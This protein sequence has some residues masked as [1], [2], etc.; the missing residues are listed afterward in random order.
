MSAA[1]WLDL[2]FVR[3]VMG[4]HVGFDVIDGSVLPNVVLGFVFRQRIG[5]RAVAFVGRAKVSVR[6]PLQAG[7][8]GTR[9]A[10]AKAVDLRVARE[11]EVEPSAP[12]LAEQGRLVFGGRR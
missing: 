12:E 4:K 6:G 5:W 8:F 3:R 11:P 9:E 2:K 1:G 7:T 10:A